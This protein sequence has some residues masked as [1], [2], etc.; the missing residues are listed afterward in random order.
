MSVVLN[1]GMAGRHLAG[2]RTSQSILMI[3]IFKTKSIFKT[4]KSM[5]ACISI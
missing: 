3:F 2:E 1:D 4:K 5:F